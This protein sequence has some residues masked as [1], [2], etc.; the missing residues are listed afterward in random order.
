MLR[1]MDRARQHM[2][3]IAEAM[4]ADAE[5]RRRRAASMTALERI[6]EGLRLGH[7]LPLTDAQLEALDRRAEQQADI[8]RKWRA[9]QRR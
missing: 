5:E 4:E 2:R 1:G 8:H 6:V 9:L 7:A 3:A